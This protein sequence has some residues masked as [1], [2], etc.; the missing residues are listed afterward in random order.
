M[1]VMTQG[2]HGFSLMEVLVAMVVL[3]VG[4]L[5]LAALQTQGMR[6][7]NEAYF[8]TQANNAAYQFIAMMRADRENLADYMYSAAQLQDLQGGELECSENSADSA[9]QVL[10]GI[11]RLTE[12]LPGGQATIVQNVI[13]DDYVDVTI[14]W[15]DRAASTS[16]L[17]TDKTQ[18]T[19]EVQPNRIW[20]ASGVAAGVPAVCRVNQTWV[21]YP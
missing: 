16:T 12:V 14:S 5:G 1:D 4:L 2:Q 21:V 20:D 3:S 10:C 6:Y 7:N 9:V 13:D 15:V 19:C 8:R 17:E 18:A 11:D